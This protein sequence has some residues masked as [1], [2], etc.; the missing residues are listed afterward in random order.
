MVL[1]D[2]WNATIVCALRTQYE[3]L[4]TDLATCRLN[5]VARRAL[6]LERHNVIALLLGLHRAG[7]SVV[8]H[9]HANLFV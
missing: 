5:D 3:S 9:A 6:E 7:C 4:S 8:S 2:R 1:N